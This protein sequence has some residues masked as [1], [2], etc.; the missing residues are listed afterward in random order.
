[1]KFK[2]EVDVADII[3]NLDREYFCYD[4]FEKEV[5]SSIKSSIIF[6][7]KQVILNKI[8]DDTTKEIGEH[9]ISNLKNISES[10]KT[11]IT[12][13]ILSNQ[14]ISPYPYSSQK[15]KAK[16]YIYKSLTERAK[17][18]IEKIVK[19]TA[20]DICKNLKDRYDIAFATAIVDNLRKQNMLD[21]K[22]ASLLLN[23]ENK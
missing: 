14:E 23:N 12:N 22:V 20:A 11:E 17:S 4:D 7:A 13:E 8:K 3:E 9:I 18:C 10:I 19:E 6:E 16:D 5:I 15:V 2:I 1:M 21:E